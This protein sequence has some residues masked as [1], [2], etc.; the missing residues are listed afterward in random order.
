MDLTK[1][2]V[3]LREERAQIEEAILILERLARGRGKRRGRP[4]LW[5]TQG[6][7]GTDSAVKRR[8]RPPGSKNKPKEQNSAS[9]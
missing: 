2:L 3:E 7:G 5:M 1:M 6:N 8:G 9:A 4:P